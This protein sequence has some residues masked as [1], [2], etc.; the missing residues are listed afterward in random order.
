M[1]VD[2]FDEQ[3]AARRRALEPQS[4][5]SNTAS[6]R[7]DK[8]IADAF[9]PCPSRYEQ[10][11]LGEFLL[12]GTERWYVARTLPRQE[13]RAEFHL[14]QQ[15]IRAF[16]PRATKT[17]RHAR[18]LRTVN[19]P[20][21]PGYIF[22]VL[23]VRRDRWRA[24]NGTFGVASLIMGGEQPLPVP[25]NVVEHLLDYTDQSGI[26]RFDRD[27]REGQSVR[28]TTGPF[29]GALGYLERL[30]P[31]GRVRVLLDIMGGNVPMLLDRA[32]LEAV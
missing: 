14:R 12:T 19:A 7:N 21:F 2:A 8:S 16:L 31:K 25:P 27:L 10:W 11:S 32:T 30:D 17:V 28:V 13:A 29:T 15:G 24:V 26:V 3:L 20:F 18:K 9:Q 4:V 6:L 1:A 23:D 22:A 5:S